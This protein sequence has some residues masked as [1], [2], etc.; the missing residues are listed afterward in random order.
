MFVQKE[1]V[2]RRGNSV[3]ALQAYN[4]KFKLVAIIKGQV[5]FKLMAEGQDGEESDWNNEVEVH[6]IDMCPIFTTPK[7][8]YR[9]LIHYPTRLFTGTLDFKAKKS[10]KVEINILPSN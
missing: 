1:L 9:D 10:T 7:T 5:I 6:M 8:W 2:E 3:T 4:L